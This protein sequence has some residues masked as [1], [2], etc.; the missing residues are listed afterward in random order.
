MFR[1]RNERLVGVFHN[2]PAEISL[3]N[4]TIGDSEIA[5]RIRVRL[6]RGSVCGAEAAA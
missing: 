3:N 4:I 6:K 5:R 2:A 1:Q